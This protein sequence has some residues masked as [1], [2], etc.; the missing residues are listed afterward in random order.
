M[1]EKMDRGWTYQCPGNLP[2]WLW[3]EAERW[4]SEA[5]ALGA[6]VLFSGKKHVGEISH[7]LLKLG[8]VLD[9]V[10]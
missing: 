5:K 6:F 4:D 7:M 1:V 10:R 9:N 2:A 3:P 8:H